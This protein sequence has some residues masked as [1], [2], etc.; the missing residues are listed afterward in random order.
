VPVLLVLVFRRRRG[1][2]LVRSFYDETWTRQR[3]PLADDGHGNT[4]PNWAGTLSTA[5]VTGCRLQPIS[6][7]ELMEN[8]FESDVRNRLLA[9]YGSS[10]TYLDRMLSPTSA[11]WEVV[12]VQ[13]FN[14]PTGV[15]QHDEILLRKVTL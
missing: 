15:A 10:V 2:P 7:D 5:T 12:E 1:S 3:A 6:A 11:V 9:P 14:S 8:R 13:S 4:A